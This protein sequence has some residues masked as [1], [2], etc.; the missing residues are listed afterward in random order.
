MR[1]ELSIEHRT[2]DP[3]YEINTTERYIRTDYQG[4]QC[5]VSF[6]EAFTRAI[7]CLEHIES[8]ELPNAQ[9]NLFLAVYIRYLKLLE[10]TDGPEPSY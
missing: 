8:G 6:D 5:T 7:D 4:I 9:E 2:G 3:H 10:R 1:K